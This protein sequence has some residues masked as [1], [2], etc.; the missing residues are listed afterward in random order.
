[1]IS[2]IGKAAPTTG[3]GATKVDY[4]GILTVLDKAPP[5]NSFRPQYMAG[6][7]TDLHDRRRRLEPAARA[8][9]A[10]RLH[11]HGLHQAHRLPQPGLARPRQH[12]H[13]A[14]PD[15]PR[16]ALPVPVVERRL[17]LPPG[18]GARPHGA[19]GAD[20]SS[21]GEE[22]RHRLIQY[23]I[24]LTG[25][26]NA[27]GMTWSRQAGFGVGRKWPLL[28]AEMML[29]QDWS[30]PYF[31]TGSIG[32]LKF[33]EDDCTYFGPDDTPRWGE[34][35]TGAPWPGTFTAPTTPAGRRRA[36]STS[37]P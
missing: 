8:G 19:A 23:G 34:I 24:D 16:P 3:G 6:E 12:Q 30:I 29:G 13:P 7:K 17:S 35:C 33:Q 5:A 28:F 2:S 10:D 18:A 32:V 11:G 37:T 1:M 4:I 15:L 26:M 21:G 31:V 9:R 14:R 36:T 22:R 25:S 20:R 27:N